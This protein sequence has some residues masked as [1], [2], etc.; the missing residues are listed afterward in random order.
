MTLLCRVRVTMTNIAM[1]CANWY[2]ACPVC[3]SCTLLMSWCWVVLAYQLAVAVQHYSPL[4]RTSTC[5][6]VATLV[7]ALPFSLSPP[8]NATLGMRYE[9]LC[10]GGVAVWRCMCGNGACYRNLLFHGELSAPLEEV[11]IYSYNGGGE[12][13]H[14]NLIEHQ[15]LSGRR[16]RERGR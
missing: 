6:E 4:S 5:C 7:A 15:G 12:G 14:H 11:S 8:R 13:E 9:F 3:I 1:K 2:H 10:D 16:L